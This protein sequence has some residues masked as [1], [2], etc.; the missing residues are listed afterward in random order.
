MEELGEY[1]DRVKRVLSLFFSQHLE[2]PVSDT[3][4][5][6][7]V[8]ICQSKEVKTHGRVLKLP[9][10]ALTTLLHLKQTTHIQVLKSKNNTLVL[11]KVEVTINRRSRLN[12]KFGVPT[13]FLARFPIVCEDYH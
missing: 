3:K 12:H 11:V 1:F 2:R 6:V 5:V 10:S 8:E 9:R 4:Q 7:V 13:N